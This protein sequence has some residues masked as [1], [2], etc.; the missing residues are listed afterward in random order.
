MGA[1]FSLQPSKLRETRVLLVQVHEVVLVLR[2]QLA[3]VDGRL[4][5]T[6]DVVVQVYVGGLHSR[7]HQV[8]RAIHTA[9]VFVIVVPRLH[10]VVRCRVELVLRDLVQRRGR[11]ALVHRLL[12]V[13]ILLMLLLLRQSLQVERVD[14][15]GLLVDDLADVSVE[16]GLVLFGF[17]AM[18]GGG[19]QVSVAWVV[20]SEQLLRLLVD[21]NQLSLC[22][23]VAVVAFTVRVCNV[24]LVLF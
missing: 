20:P 11:R 17:H 7:G 15:D 22:L 12:L 3:M 18:I 1:S 9:Q 2:L 19:E 13:R 4:E 21:G 5:F 10:V 23:V 6:C 24:L 8:K 16:R 14:L